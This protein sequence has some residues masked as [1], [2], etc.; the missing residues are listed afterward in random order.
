MDL[1]DLDIIVDM[2][3]RLDTNCAQGMDCDH[4]GQFCTR[5]GKSVAGILYSYRKFIRTLEVETQQAMA[6]IGSTR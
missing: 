2:L 3:G 6:G 5:L 1:T 4:E